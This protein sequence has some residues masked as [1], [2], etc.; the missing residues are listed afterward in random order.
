MTDTLISS[1]SESRF[2]CS[3]VCSGEPNVLRRFFE[4]LCQGFMPG[5]W[6]AVRA[7]HFSPKKVDKTLNRPMGHD[8]S[9]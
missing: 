5:T 7:D 6:A 2:C 3:C 8:R 9:F 4:Q 1:G